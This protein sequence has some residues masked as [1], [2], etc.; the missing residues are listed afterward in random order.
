MLTRIGT[1]A[2]V[3]SVVMQSNKIVASGWAD[4]GSGRVIALARYND[5]DGS[6]DT[7]FGPESSLSISDVSKSEG[8]GGTS[9]PTEFSFEI[10]LSSPSADVVTVDYSVSGGTATAGSDYQAVT[11]T[12]RMTIPAGSVSETVTI[13]VYGDRLKEANETF[14]VYL[15]NSSGPT[16]VDDR[17]IGTIVNDD[18]VTKLTAAAFGQGTS[19]TL[20]A[21][22]S[23]ALVTEAI[24]R[25]KAGGAGTSIL[26]NLDI[27]IAD[28]ADMT[29]GEVIGQTI[30]IDSD[31][32][33][34]GWFVDSTPS[35]ER[36]F[37]MP[38]D[39]GEQDRIDL[40]TVVMHEMGHLLGYEHEDDGV[41]AETLAAGVRRT[42]VQHDQA[43]SVDNVFR[44]SGSEHADSWL[45]LWSFEQL[46]SKRSSAKRRR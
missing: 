23:S 11:G 2:G 10:A 3:R 35:D 41:M 15:A 21:P 27:R 22:V 4:T 36:E 44:Q 32:A 16:I 18:K 19:N 9:E 24:A 40:L 29:L 20:A 46:A 17:G 1:D 34:W 6:L 12:Q 43:A 45:G 30:W 14:Y 38:G 39:Q 25:W 5:N 13:L 33:G 28:F 7:T 37:A 42:D 8:N 31:A 26:E